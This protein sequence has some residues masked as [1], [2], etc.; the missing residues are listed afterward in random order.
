C[1]PLGENRHAVFFAH[2]LETIDYHYERNANDPRVGHTLTL[3]VDEFGNVLK[4]ASVGY[5]RRTPAYPEQSNTLI[6]FTDSRF[7]NKPN[8]RPNAP[9]WPQLCVTSEMRN[10][11]CPA[12]QPSGELMA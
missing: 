1:Q 2:P 11:N 4:S 6:T 9:A 3:E 8:D 5:P 12:A 10:F 7:I